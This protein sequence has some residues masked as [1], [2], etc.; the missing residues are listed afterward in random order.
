MAT[1]KRI[2]VIEDDVDIREAIEQ[3]LKLENFEV[4]SA[5]HGQEGLDYLRASQPLPDVILLDLMMPVKNGYEFL[6][7]KRLDSRLSSVPVVVMTANQMQ[8]DCP[9]GAI[10]FLRKPVNIDELVETLN[11]SMSA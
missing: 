5:Q 8:Q 3:I 2:L 1:Q 6:K 4:S 11:E 10:A 9:E 7:E